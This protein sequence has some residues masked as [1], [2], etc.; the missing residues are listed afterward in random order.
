MARDL[1]VHLMESGLKMFVRIRVIL[2]KAQV[3]VVTISG[4]CEK[5]MAIS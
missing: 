1:S 4:F 5:S 3:G 2:V